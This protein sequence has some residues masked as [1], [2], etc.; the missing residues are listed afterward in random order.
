MRHAPGEKSVIHDC[1][2]PSALKR[3][4]LRVVQS[5]V[6]IIMYAAL[7]LAASKSDMMGHDLALAVTVLLLDSFPLLEHP[8][9]HCGIKVRFHQSQLTVQSVD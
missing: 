2:V 5:V 6:N 8:P 3:V 1:V 4:N 7:Q 9:P